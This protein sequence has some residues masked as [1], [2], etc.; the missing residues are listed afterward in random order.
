MQNSKAIA[1]VAQNDFLW[2][3]DSREGGVLEQTLLQTK[4]FAKLITF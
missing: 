4:L 3:I 2:D 1:E